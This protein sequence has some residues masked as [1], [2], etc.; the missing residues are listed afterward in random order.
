M[1]SWIAPLLWGYGGRDGGVQHRQRQ[2]RLH[3]PHE[4]AGPVG[5]NEPRRHGKCVVLIG[6]AAI[7][8]TVRRSGQYLEPVLFDDCQQLERHTARPFGS[9]L[10][11]LHRGF[12]G[13]QKARMVAL[14][15]VPA[16]CSPRAAL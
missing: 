11:F 13:V 14:W 6:R 12:A 1:G 4:L 8:V 9:G 3:K 2:I 16:R 5:F 7:G 15:M 10:P